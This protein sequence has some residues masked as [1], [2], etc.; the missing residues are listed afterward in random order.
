[1]TTQAAHVRSNLVKILDSEIAEQVRLLEAMRET[2]RK[3][4]A[5]DVTAPDATSQIV[6]ISNRL[7]A[8]L[9]RAL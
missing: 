3:M 4:K 7:Y 5:V 8:G 6:A 2:L 9:G 1:M